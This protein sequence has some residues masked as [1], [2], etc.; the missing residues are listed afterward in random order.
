MI[1]SNWSTDET[2]SASGTRQWFWVVNPASKE[3]YLF[4]LTKETT[5]EIWVEKIASEVISIRFPYAGDLI[6]N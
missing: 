5:G 3:R 1:I 4:K 6:C 2:L